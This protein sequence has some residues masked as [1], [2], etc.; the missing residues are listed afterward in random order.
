MC[1]INNTNNIRLNF[2]FKWLFVSLITFSI[3]VCYGKTMTVVTEELPPYQFRENGNITGDSYHKVERILHCANIQ[4]EYLF[5][6]W[7]R[8]YNYVLSHNNTLIFSMAKIPSRINKFFWVAPVGHTHSF[9]YKLSTRTDI[10][11]NSIQDIKKYRMGL[12][13]EDSVTKYLL[14][15]H[16]VIKGSYDYFRTRDQKFKMFMAGRFDL[17]EQVEETLDYVIKEYHY[18]A[19]D[20]K[21]LIPLDLNQ[22]LYLAMNHQSDKKIYQQLKKCSQQLSSKSQ[23]GKGI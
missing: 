1:E 19:E 15:H 18:R 20:F 14:N 11:V 8:A 17:I 4:G 9:I 10:K 3:S 22:T 7:P 16:Y 21:K 12:V 6:P 2:R 23:K 13:K 5:L